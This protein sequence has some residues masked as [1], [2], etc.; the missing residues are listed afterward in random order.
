MARQANY[1]AKIE[2]LE[3]DMITANES[4]DSV[5]LMDL[6][7]EFQEIQE[8]QNQALDDWESASISLEAFY[9]DN[10]TLL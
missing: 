9:E 1:E 4:G 7:K 8:Q 2:K 6:H 10:P 3:A 5:K